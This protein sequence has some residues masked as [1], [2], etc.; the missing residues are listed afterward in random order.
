MKPRLLFPLAGNSTPGSPARPLVNSSN[1]NSTLPPAATLDGSASDID[2]RLCCALVT[3][4]SR[5]TIPGFGN[6]G[7]MALAVRGNWRSSTMSV[8]ATTPSCIA[9][10][11]ISKLTASPG[12]SVK[13]PAVP[14]TNLKSPETEIDLVVTGCLSK[15]RKLNRRLTPTPG[16]RIPKSIPSGRCTAASPANRVAPASDLPITN[17]VRVPACSTPLNDPGSS[18]ANRTVKGSDSPTASCRGVGGRS[19]K[20]KAVPAIES[21]VSVTLCA[22]VLTRFTFMS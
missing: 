15:F 16:S 22:P 14:V 1:A 17:V 18:G 7:I 13:G 10:A 9:S 8:P 3:A 4:A 6:G 19:S 12:A 2:S 11:A 20:D 21:V 5:N